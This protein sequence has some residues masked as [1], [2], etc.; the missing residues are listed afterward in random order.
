MKR[1]TAKQDIYCMK[2]H[3]FISISLQTAEETKTQEVRSDL[4]VSVSLQRVR[5]FVL[6]LK[7]LLFLSVFK[8]K[9][10]N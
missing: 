6:I 10:K 2:T 9:M 1:G 8:I 4:Y 7:K 3:N 5:M